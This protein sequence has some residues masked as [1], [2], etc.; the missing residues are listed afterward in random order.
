MLAVFP[1]WGDMKGVP[2]LF[3]LPQ[4]AVSQRPSG[5]KMYVSFQVAK[6]QTFPLSD[7]TLT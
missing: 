5:R 3:F 7:K 4:V 6:L 2:L 1:R